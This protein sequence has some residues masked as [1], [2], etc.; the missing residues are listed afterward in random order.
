MGISVDDA[1]G[2]CLL[3]LHVLYL[4][5]RPF[6]CR[7]SKLMLFFPDNDGLGT[8]NNSFKFSRSLVISAAAVFSDYQSSCAVNSFRGRNKGENFSSNLHDISHSVDFS[9]LWNGKYTGK[10][11]NSSGRKA[12]L[13]SGGVAHAYLQRIKMAWLKS[14]ADE[15]W[16]LNYD[17]MWLC[18]C[19]FL[20]HSQNSSCTV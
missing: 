5:D 3:I 11:E 15:I 7:S 10:R 8:N 2:T 17:A 13:I 6:D 18:S 14:K 9:S 16:R 20:C 19:W 1:P 12:F 4:P